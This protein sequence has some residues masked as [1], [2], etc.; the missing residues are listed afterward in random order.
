[1]LGFFQSPKHIFPPIYVARGK[2]TRGLGANAVYHTQSASGTQFDC[3][4]T[5]EHASI[6]PGRMVINLSDVTGE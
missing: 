2:R 3:S 4:L 1:M 5:V 6:R